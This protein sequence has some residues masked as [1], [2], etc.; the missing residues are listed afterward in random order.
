L[1]QTTFVKRRLKLL[2][3]IDEGVI[4]I[5]SA[6]MI[7]KSNDTEFPFR[8]D[9]NFRY[10]TGF[11]E[12]DCLLVMIKGSKTTSTL[13]LR[14]KDDFTE[15]W[16]G[17][18]LGVEQA[19]ERLDVDDAYPIEEVKT[20]LPE[21]ILGHQNIYY[22]LTDAKL[23]KLVMTAFTSVHRMRKS[24]VTKPTS[25]HHLAP[26]LGTLKLRKSGKEILAMRKGMEQT[27]LGHRALMAMSKAGLNERKLERTLNLAFSDNLCEGTAYDSIV[28]SGDNALILHYVENNSDLKDGDLVLIDAGA[29]FNGYA[30]DVS[31]TYPVSGKFT[32]AQKIVYQL[33]LDAQKASLSAAKPG[34]TLTKMHEEACKVL[35][36]G[37]IQHGILKGSAEEELKS[38][39]FR[40]Y[41]PHGTGHW[42]G[43]DVHDTCPYLTNDNEDMPFEEGMVMTCEPGLYF[44]RGDEQV[45]ESWQGIGIRIEDDIVI[46]KN[47]YENLSSMIPKEIKEVEE[48]CARS[49]D[50]LSLL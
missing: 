45:P 27:D 2:E 29:Q 12:P 4:L 47:G 44:A 46:T 25:F 16:M 34:S 19:C 40:K 6:S 7:T 35:V 13:F 20:K 18:R 8:Q 32:D 31:R 17:K 3:L 1:E 9:S 43:L 11:N 42:L 36:E 21:L 5:P 48:A 22:D 39:T 38:G 24:K 28:A 10:L 15:M 26:L 30:T 50:S 49:I 23:A 37:L 33:V 14:P 41:Y